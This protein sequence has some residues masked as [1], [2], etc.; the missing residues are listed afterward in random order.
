M[1]A[2]EVQSGLGRPVRRLRATSRTSCPTS[3]LGKALGGG[4]LPLSAVVADADVL[5]VP[6]PGSHGSTFPAATRSPWPWDARCPPA[7]DRRA[8][9]GARDLEPVLQDGLAPLLG[10]G[11]VGLRVRGCGRA[12]PRPG[13]GHW[14][15]TSARSVQG[16][17]VKTRTARPSGSRLR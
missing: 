11:L 3:I 4:I 16:V 10:D 8:A 13:A 14:G 6:I 17:L 5:G 15:A 1:V 9:G 12:R 7:R 2:D